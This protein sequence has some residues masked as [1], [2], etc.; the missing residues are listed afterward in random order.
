METVP[1][2]KMLDKWDD[3]QL[4]AD[5]TAV[6]PKESLVYPVLGL[7]GEAGEF[8]VSLVSSCHQE[9]INEAGDVL[10]YC[11]EICTSRGIRLSECWRRPDGPTPNRFNALINA[12]RLAEAYK[13][14]IRSGLDAPVTGVITHIIGEVIL[15]VDRVLEA[16]ELPTI[17]EVMAINIEKLAARAAAGTLKTR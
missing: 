5:K 8:M 12:S 15:A 17:P 16:M 13:K 1:W 7:V 14:A 11:A 9:I 4:A 2:Q 3:Y 10:W 6:Y